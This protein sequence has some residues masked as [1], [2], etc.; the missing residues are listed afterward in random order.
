MHWRIRGRGD[1]CPVRAA[2]SACCASRQ[3]A[4]QREEQERAALFRSFREENVRLM[5]ALQIPE[6]AAHDCSPASPL[7]AA[8]NFSELAELSR[9]PPVPSELAA[10]LADPAQEKLSP[11][12][13]AVA[14]KHMK[15][16]L[17][18]LR[19]IEAGRLEAVGRSRE[20]IAEARAALG[21]LEA[22]ERADGRRQRGQL[23]RSNSH[24]VFAA[25][26]AA[27]LPTAECIAAHRDIEDMLESAR[28]IPRIRPRPPSTRA[29]GG[30]SAPTTTLSPDPPSRLLYALP[31]ELSAP[32][33]DAREAVERLW[34]GMGVPREERE[35]ALAGASTAAGL[36]LALRA[37]R[38]R[39]RA[40]RALADS[41]A[42]RFG[43]E[44]PPSPR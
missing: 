4:A 20:R 7:A 24:S 36:L 39:L 21:A 25:V 23:E 32:L 40:A 37:E 11:A 5:S 41:V 38:G 19:A 33:A 2:A 6:S 28:G 29:H 8:S 44:T 12:E 1:A 15:A 35:S 43:S 42:V 26:R 34:A 17:A 3:A 9:V 13:M 18:A 22:E 30:T 31:Q 16:R 10:K 14:A 27:P